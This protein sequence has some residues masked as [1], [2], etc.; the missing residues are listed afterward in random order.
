MGARNQRLLPDKTDRPRPNADYMTR[1]R[2][3]PTLA[4]LAGP[5]APLLPP[6][7]LRMC[8]A[9]PSGRGKLVEGLWR[10]EKRLKGKL[11]RQTTPENPH[12]RP[13]SRGHFADRPKLKWKWLGPLDWKNRVRADARRAI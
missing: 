8:A 3:P 9:P 4:E 10:S 5:L 7:N 13:A 1:R 2:A 12:A 6:P 11:N